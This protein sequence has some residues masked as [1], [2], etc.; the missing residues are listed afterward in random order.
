[1]YKVLM[2]QVI[3]IQGW[4]VQA[5]FSFGQQVPNLR[6]LGKIAQFFYLTG[7]IRVFSILVISNFCKRVKSREKGCAAA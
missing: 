2:G 5:Y 4:I 7:N 3:W 1:M 6:L